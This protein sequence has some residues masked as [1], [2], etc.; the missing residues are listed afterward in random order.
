M[1]SKRI[2]FRMSAALIIVT[3]A[4]Y[5]VEARELAKPDPAPLG[6]QTT[7]PVAPPTTAPTAPAGS[8]GSTST[9]TVIVPLPS[10]QEAPVVCPSP[11]PLN[12]DTL[13]MLN[14]VETLVGTALDSK[15]EATQKATAT[16]TVGRGLEGLGRVSVNRADLDEIRADIEQVKVMLQTYIAK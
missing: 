13:V 1:F 4:A 11:T 8:G 3:A 5:S 12:G 15:I 10:S 14:R 2:A 6:Q 16:G 7:P 9:A